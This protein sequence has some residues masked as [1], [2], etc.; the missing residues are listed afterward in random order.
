MSRPPGKTAGTIIGVW[1]LLRLLTSVLAGAF[2]TLRPLTPVEKSLPLWPPSGDLLAWLERALVSPW[3][4]W[5]SVWFTRIVSRGFAA[6][7]GTTNFHPLYPWLA[8]PL[9]RLGL[10]PTLS[11]LVVSSLASLALLWIFI[12]LA[13]LDLS[14]QASNTA[15]LS[16]VT[17][18]V[19]F[20][21]FAP[22]SEGLFLFW[23]ALCLYSARL[24]R[25]LPA[26]AAAFLATLTRQQGLFLVIPLAWSAWEASGRS[27]RGLPK[28]AGGWL[29]V[30]AAPAGMAAWTV[31]RLAVLHEGSLDFH[32]LQGLIYSAFVSPSAHQVVPVQAFLWPWQALGL[33]ISKAVHA[34]DA[35]IWID[36]LVAA[37]F[38]FILL[39]A[40]RHLK[41]GDRLFVLTITAVSL[42]Y[43]TGPVHPYMGLPRHLFVA[44]PVFTG[45]GAALRKPWQQAS[46]LGV[47]TLGFVLLLMTYVLEAWVL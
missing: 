15:L 3:L 19:A 4:R 40:W 35:D 43:Y 12:K 16:L 37:W 21:L 41:T 2:S 1:V 31:Y 26:A 11:L 18:P 28:A 34:P 10:D 45:L 25:F 8:V 38:L 17:F 13:Q 20:A 33:A 14:R 29:A 5:D 22:Y 23:V 36:L 42:C 32:N 46:V 27:L 44:L 39:A 47:Q 6:G 24:G 30:L 9:Y 7:D